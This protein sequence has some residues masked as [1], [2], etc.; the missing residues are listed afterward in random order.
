MIVGI[1]LNCEETEPGSTT[2]VEL[3]TEGRTVLVVTASV[4]QVTQQDPAC[5]GVTC[6]TIVFTKSYSRR[7][8]LDPETLL[9]IAFDEQGH[10]DAGR[11]FDYNQHTAV[12]SEFV[13]T[14]A[15]DAGFF[16]PPATS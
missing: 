14:T 11:G 2:T 4:P 8:T 15:Y 3:D 12:V 5:S 7:V 9:P 10:M 6:P 1:A 13:D 16:T